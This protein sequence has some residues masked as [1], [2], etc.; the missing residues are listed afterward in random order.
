ML[1]NLVLFLIDNKINGVN[2]HELLR[3][4]YKFQIVTRKTL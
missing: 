4:A 1:Y 3:S 2:L